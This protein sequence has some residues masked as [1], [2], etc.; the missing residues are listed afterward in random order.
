MAGSISIRF[1]GQ[2]FRATMERGANESLSPIAY[3]ISGGA[4]EAAVSLLRRGRAQIARSGNFGS[5]RWLQGLH[6]EA[7]P[8]S[9]A[10][11]NAAIRMWH[12]IWYA[13]IH[14]FGGIIRGNPLLWIPL[15]FAPEAKGI[16]ARDYPGGLFRVDRRVGR[17]L[18]LSRVDKQPKYFGIAEVYIPPRW[19]LSELSQSIMDNF[20]TFYEKNKRFK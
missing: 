1:E 14:E 15:S 7:Q 8:R 10:L 4:R 3:G 13:H 17:P 11:T 19:G 18:L 20:V 5:A 12:D 2:R 9:G 6:V 16:Y